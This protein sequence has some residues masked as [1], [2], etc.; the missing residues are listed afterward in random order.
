ML[1]IIPS[2]PGNRTTSGYYLDEKAVLG[3]ELY[4][5]FWPG[6]VLTLFREGD[7]SAILFGREYTLEDL[8]FD[9]QIVTNNGEIDEINLTNAA[10]IAASGDN[11]LDFPL[12]DICKKIDVPLV[13][14][15]EYI[16][17][18]RL[19]IIALDKGTKFSKIKSAVWTCLSERD[20]RR[21]F[22][23]ASGLQ[24]NGTP[25]GN[26][27]ASLTPDLITYFDTRMP[28]ALMATD[29]EIERKIERLKAGQP[30]RLGFSGRLDPMKGSDHL[31]YTAEKLRLAGCDFSLDIFGSGSLEQSM[32]DRIKQSQLASHVRIHPPID[33]KTALVPFFRNDIDLF[34]CCHRQADPSCTYMEAMGCGV[35]ISGYGNKAFMGLLNLAPIGRSA[36][37]GS[38]YALARAVLALDADRATLGKMMWEAR[39]LSSRNDVESTFINRV[40]HL[41]RLAKMDVGRKTEH[42]R[43]I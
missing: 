1:L 26:A 40:E 14:F 31:I 43:Q 33:F 28:R 39:N 27:Y 13:Y 37:M 16:L 25:A 10:I 41:V 17:E 30:L 23:K 7:R 5:R 9:V 12:A 20:R 8:P 38:P 11:F 15:I 18:T 42:R 32:Q 36:R 3:L 21:A 24:A 4:A 22:R 34:L 35:P 2:V 29:V 6:R 19:Q